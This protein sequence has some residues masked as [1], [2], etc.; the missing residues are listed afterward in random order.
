MKVLS[1][2]QPW[3]SLV[4]CGAKKIE[5]RSWRCPTALIGQRIAIH[6][7]K[8]FP[9]DAKDAC[10]ELAFFTALWPDI[11]EYAMDAPR[12]QGCYIGVRRG[13]TETIV[14]TDEI[15]RMTN[16]LPRGVILATA[17]ISGCWSTN[18]ERLV[19]RIPRDEAMFGNYAPDRWMWGLADVEVLPAPI[20]AKGALGLW[21][22][23]PGKERAA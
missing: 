16:L 21:T 1:L 23:E 5:T 13:A 18:Q 10:L 12:P 8:G 7:S 22:W 6:A 3:A 15:D 2:T 17:R 20:P 14:S 9:R 4:A 11:Q 19:D